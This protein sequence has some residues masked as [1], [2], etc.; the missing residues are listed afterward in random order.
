MSS[1][2]EPSP[3]GRIEPEP[4]TVVHEEPERMTGVGT[5]GTVGR[6]QIVG[7][8]NAEII[9]A[10]ALSIPVMVKIEG[11]SRVYRMDLAIK[12]DGFKPE[13]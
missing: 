2:E 8:D 10:N 3:A 6:I 4:E 11:D 5:G 7:T 13:G 9:S 12:L 1:Y